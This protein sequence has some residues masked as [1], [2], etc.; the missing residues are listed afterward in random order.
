M[1]ETRER[2]LIRKKQAWQ[3]V[4][5]T[6]ALSGGWSLRARRGLVRLAKAK[7]NVGIR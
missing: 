5:A 4:G 7:Y 1:Q 2:G 6:H 3:F